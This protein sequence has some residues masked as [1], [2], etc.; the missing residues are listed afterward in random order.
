LAECGRGHDDRAANAGPELDV[1]PRTRELRVC[2]AADHKPTPA[3]NTVCAGVAVFGADCL[4]LRVLVE[5]MLC[6]ALV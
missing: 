6:N 2:G 1:V 4:L 3:T 5:L